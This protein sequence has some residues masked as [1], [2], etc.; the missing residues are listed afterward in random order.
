MLKE[1]KACSEL[2]MKNILKDIN[3]NMLNPNKV[4][5]YLE[6]LNKYFIGYVSLKRYV[7]DMF[8]MPY[9]TI[10]YVEHYFTTSDFIYAKYFEIRLFP[11]TAKIT[12]PIN[13]KIEQNLNPKFYIF[14]G[15]DELI[16][17]KEVDNL[18]TKI[19]W[20][21]K[22]KFE[23][24]NEEVRW[25]KGGKLVGK[26]PEFYKEKKIDTS[27]IIDHNFIQFLENHGALEEYV[28]YI[29]TD[30]KNN[31][32]D[33]YDE[34]II[35]NSIVWNKTDSGTSFWDNLNTEWKRTYREIYGG[36]DEDDDNWDDENYYDY[37]E[38]DHED[39]EVPP[40]HE[41]VRWYKKGKLGMN[42]ELPKEEKCYED[43]ITDNT[44]RQFLIDNNVYDEYVKYTHNYIKKSFKNYFGEGIILH[45][46]KWSETPPN[47]DFWR[48]LH[49]K[50]Y[51][52]Y[53]EN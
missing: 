19:R 34:Y 16:K 23:N 1:D 42:Y 45:S 44:F 5:D 8:N 51:K 33:Y 21:K 25:F 49:E 52:T 2:K 28:E 12:Y 26:D 47:T 7:A 14:T 20:Y 43:F 30:Y 4:Y 27:F 36:D 46:F 39:D 32:N 53:K 48:R 9:Y 17:L 24:S 15:Q 41:G 22:G 13:V 31:F 29:K 6:I 37:D 35:E 18:K 10:A 38:D 50:W 11:I 40:L 3:I